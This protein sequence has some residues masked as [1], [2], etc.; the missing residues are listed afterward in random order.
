MGICP[1]VTADT[2]YRDGFLAPP[3][4]LDGS[5]FA[6]GPKERQKLQEKLSELCDLKHDLN[7]AVLVVTGNL[8]HI[9]NIDDKDVSLNLVTPELEG[10]LN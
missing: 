2:A 9:K 8:E 10:L 1:A 4:G 3:G 5:V 6:M 7:S